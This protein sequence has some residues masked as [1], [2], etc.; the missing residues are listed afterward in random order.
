MARYLDKPEEWARLAAYLAKEPVIGLDTEFDKDTTRVTVWSVAAFHPT[1]PIH[2][3]GY[4]VAIGYVLPAA[5]LETFRGLLE[6]ESTTKVLHNAPA[7]TRSIY[8]T[9]GVALGSALCSL[10]YARVVWPGLEDYGLKG[11]SRRMLG[12]PPRPGFKEVMAYRARVVRQVAKVTKVCSCGVPGCRKRK[13]HEKT[14]VTTMVDQVSER[15]A[16]YVPSELHPG[17]PRWDAWLAYAE[18]DAVD[19][20][21]L[22]DYIERQPPQAPGDVFDPALIA[23]ALKGMGE[24]S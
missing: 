3:R 1:R 22:W 24:C 21:E 11:L 9:A 6:S 19:A 14:P 12:K 23:Q 7:D 5:A 16:E 13:G 17:H 10:Q 8:D 20:L 18:E 15:D 4:R 2:P